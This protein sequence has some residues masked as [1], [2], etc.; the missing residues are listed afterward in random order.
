MTFVALTYSSVLT[1]TIT[2][3]SDPDACP[4]VRM[5]RAILI[6]E[7]RAFASLRQT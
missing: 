3:V 6:G 5:L 1:I 2:I 4:D 7:L